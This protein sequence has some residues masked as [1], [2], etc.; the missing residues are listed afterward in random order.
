MV[1]TR[2]IQAPITDATPLIVHAVMPHGDCY[3]CTGSSKTVKVEGSIVSP[4]SV[5]R[6]TASI[7]SPDDP[8]GSGISL[9]DPVQVGVGTSSYQ[10]LGAEF[11][12]PFPLNMGMNVPPNFG[13]FNV[14]DASS[15]HHHSTLPAGTFNPYHS[16]NTGQKR[17]HPPSPADGRQI[18]RRRL[19][20]NTNP[21]VSIPSLFECPVGM[22]REEYERILLDK[23]AAMQSRRV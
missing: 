6:V 15:V 20:A 4:P 13:P 9:D 18:K 7:G 22:S 5:P 10:G 17:A 8:Q 19:E 11:T 2:I 3:G 12:Y 1:L 14:S 21:S 16:L 23:L